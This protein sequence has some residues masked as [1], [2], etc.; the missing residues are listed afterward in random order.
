MSAALHPTA[1]VEYWERLA[2]E[3]RA[4]ADEDR[5]LRRT[6]ESIRIHEANA[7]EYERQAAILRGLP[8]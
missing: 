2:R 1:T 6:V 3:E 5:A 4:F 7:L 8:A